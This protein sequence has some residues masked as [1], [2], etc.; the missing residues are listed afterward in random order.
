MEY[1]A[2]EIRVADEEVV[3][4]ILKAAG[5]AKHVW[6][7][8]N[9]EYRLK[10]YIANFAK[11]LTDFP[12]LSI[13]A[14]FKMRERGIKYIAGK[15]VTKNGIYRLNSNL[16]FMHGTN[17]GIMAARKTGEEWGKGAVV[18]GHVHKKQ[19]WVD[20]KGCGIV[21]GKLLYQRYT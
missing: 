17:H 15:G 1:V 4:P 13:Q 11:A 20:K 9:H 12:G 8:G 2:D 18:Q 5:N 21:T 14:A 7:E 19:S 6:L 3:Q 16:T 10:A